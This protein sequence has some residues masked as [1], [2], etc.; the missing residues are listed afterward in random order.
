MSRGTPVDSLNRSSSS[1]MPSDQP[2]PPPTLD[3]FPI[4]I[5]DRICA[6]LVENLVQDRTNP[7]YPAAWLDAIPNAAA[8]LPLAQA[9]KWLRQVTEPWLYKR[10]CFE[11]EDYEVHSAMALIRHF[12]KYPQYGLLVRDAF[13]LGLCWRPVL[14]NSLLELIPNIQTLRV[15][16]IFD[17]LPV[18]L[19]LLNSLTPLLM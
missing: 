16:N 12:Q 19:L 2:R 14:A 3:S 18:S 5:V 11:V 8:L 6:S 10:I 15:G 1:T 13:L 9:S 7:R 4:K 17:L